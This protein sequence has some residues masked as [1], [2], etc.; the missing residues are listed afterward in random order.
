LYSYCSPLRGFIAQYALFTIVEKR[1]TVVDGDAC[2]RMKIVEP[3]EHAGCWISD[4]DH[5]V[6]SLAE[7]VEDA[8]AVELQRRTLVR[9]AR[10][11]K[12]AASETGGSGSS[13]AVSASSSRHSY[14]SGKMDVSAET[15]FLLSG[16]QRHAQVGPDVCYSAA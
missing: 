8:R 16:N 10:K 1:F 2:I 6:Q 13:G 12:A 9:L 14:I 11:Q 7:D 5:I 3:A 15:S 4:K